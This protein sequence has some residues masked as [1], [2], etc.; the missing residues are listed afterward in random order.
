LGKCLGKKPL[1]QR[2]SPDGKKL[3]YTV[4]SSGYDIWSY[5][6]DRGVKA[7]L[8]FGSAATQASISPVWSPDGKRVAFSSVRAGKYGIYEKPMDGSG[9][10][11]VLL[12]ATDQ[13]KYLNDWSPD[14]NFLACQQTGA[15]LFQIWILPLMGDR[16]P[17]AFL[18]SPFSMRGAVFSPDGKW[19]SYCSNES[20]EVRVYVSAFPGPGGK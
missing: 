12:E 6:I 10:E 5:D 18:P 15:G 3:V 1:W 16:K 11:T 9:T 7:R 13:L 14:G 19:L 17:C 20:G 4:S 2:V 8:T